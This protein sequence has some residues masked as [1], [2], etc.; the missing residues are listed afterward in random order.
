MESSAFFGCFV[1][2]QF[3]NPFYNTLTARSCANMYFTEN[4][5]T[6]P[7]LE[8]AQFEFGCDCVDG[9][10][11]NYKGQCIPEA[12]CNLWEAFGPQ[13]D[14][15]SGNQIHDATATKGENTIET[16]P[17]T[18]QEQSKHNKFPNNNENNQITRKQ[19]EEDIRI[20]N[21]NY[22]QFNPD[23]FEEELYGKFAKNTH[24][25]QY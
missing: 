10:V 12:Q 25:I 16:K 17:D 11:T 23:V 2:Y 5:L 6:A 18:T 22:G 9:M 4:Y 14:F 13:I 1:P 8:D 15:V 19:I 20:T 21:Q 24:C 3:V 7:R